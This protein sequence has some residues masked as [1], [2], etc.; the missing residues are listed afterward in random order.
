MLYK[1]YAKITILCM[2]AC[3]AESPSRELTCYYDMGP[4][5]L[6]FYT[7]MWLKKEKTVRVMKENYCGGKEEQHIGSNPELFA[8]TMLCISCSYMSLG[9]WEGDMS[10]LEEATC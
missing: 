2:D 4:A 1:K 6:C 10:S 8:V 5:A 3:S 9:I 7:R